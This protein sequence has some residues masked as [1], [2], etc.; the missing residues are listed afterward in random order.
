[1]TILIIPH[2]WSSVTQPTY[3]VATKKTRA[4]RRIRLTINQLGNAIV[5]FIVNRLQPLHFHDFIVLGLNFVI[6]VYCTQIISSAS[7][8]SSI[9]LYQTYFIVIFKHRSTDYD[10]MNRS[11]N[12]II[13]WG[14]AQI[15]YK[16]LSIFVM[17]LFI[18]FVHQY[19]IFCIERLLCKNKNLYSKIQPESQNYIRHGGWF[20]LFTPSIVSNALVIP[21]KKKASKK[22]SQRK[23]DIQDTRLLLV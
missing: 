2:M 17:C 19:S 18:F 23:K 16:I 5:V 11:F 13:I 1:M 22:S 6:C 9:T 3:S 8:I 14:C 15:I 21:T 12:I 10:L 20:A 7:L 4:P